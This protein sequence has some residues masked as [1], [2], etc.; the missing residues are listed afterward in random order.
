MVKIVFKGDYIGLFWKQIDREEEKTDLRQQLQLTFVKV[1]NLSG[2][3]TLCV[4]VC[5]GING[6]CIRPG[7][8]SQTNYSSVCVQRLLT[9]KRK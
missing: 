3:D 4:C 7:V 8:A 6:T 5:G 9:S 2:G 1:M